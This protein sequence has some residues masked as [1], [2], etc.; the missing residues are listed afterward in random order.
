[1][2]IELIVVGKTTH[3]YLEIC[4]AEYVSRMC[5]YTRFSMSVIP[6]LKNA[7]NLRTE[8]IKEQEADLILA[9]LQPQDRIVLLDESGSMYGSVEFAGWMQRS[10]N[11]GTR[12]LIFVVGG[13]YGF[14]DRV[15]DRAHERMSLSRMTFSHQMI[16]LLFVEQL[17][18]CFTIL[19]NEPY[20]H[21]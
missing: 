1:M 14:S 11:R 10:I 8:Q 6:E 5:H 13:A 20:H 16:R 2:N 9:R 7:K 21:Q 12:R 4:I 18:R 3:K 17:Y 19:S 15:Y